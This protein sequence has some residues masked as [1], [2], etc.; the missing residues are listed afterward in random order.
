MV[1][2]KKQSPV[3]GDCFFVIEIISTYWM[4][5]IINELKQ[6]HI[7]MILLKISTLHIPL[8]LKREAKQRFFQRH[9]I[10]NASQSFQ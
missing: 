4:N 7:Q 10:S 6:G 9:K 2:Y 3:L 5:L 1:I 8:R